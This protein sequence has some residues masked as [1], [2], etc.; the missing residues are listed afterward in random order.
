MEGTIVEKDKITVEGGNLSEKELEAYLRHIAEQYPNRKLKYLNVKLDGE[1]ADLSYDFE[2]VPF[3]RVRRITGYL[4]G[5]MDRWN[6]AKRAEERDR[7]HHSVSC[8]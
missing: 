2:P 4:V 6:N 3:E 8:C 7:V 5:T 1:Y